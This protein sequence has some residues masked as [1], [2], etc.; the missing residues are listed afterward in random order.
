MSELKI[1]KFDQIGILVKDLDKVV[2]I[3]ENLL[4][5]KSKLNILEQSSEVNY[6]GQDSTIKMKKVMQHF[7]DKQLEI[8]ELL[9]ATGPNLYS[10]FIESNRFGL[11]HLGIYTKN[12]EELIEYFKDNYNVGVIQRGKVGRVKFYYLDTEDVLGFIIELIQ[13]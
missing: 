8:V 1:P 6:K 3:L 9:D 7:G 4:V 13:I 2:K 12:A 5:F 10:E 11:H